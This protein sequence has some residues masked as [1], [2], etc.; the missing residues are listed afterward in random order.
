MSIKEVLQQVEEIIEKETGLIPSIDIRFHTT[1]NPVLEFTPSAWLTARAFSLATGQPLVP[2][3]RDGCHWF[4]IGNITI[5][6]DDLSYETY[7]AMGW[8]D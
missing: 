5:F 2:K 3:S 4:S 1:K 8:L 7:Q 6:Y